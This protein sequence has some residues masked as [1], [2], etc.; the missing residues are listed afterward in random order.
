MADGRV[1]WLHNL[2]RVVTDAHDGVVRLQGVMIDT[3]AFKQ[4][5][6]AV[7]ESEPYRSWIEGSMQGAIVHC[8]GVVRFV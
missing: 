6:G 3:T 1:A 7:Q 8:D 5:Q 4:V 2:M